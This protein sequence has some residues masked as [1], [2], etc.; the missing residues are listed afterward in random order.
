[1][2]HLGTYMYIHSSSVDYAAW[3]E[4]VTRDPVATVCEDSKSSFTSV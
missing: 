3:F 2:L 4:I 1:M